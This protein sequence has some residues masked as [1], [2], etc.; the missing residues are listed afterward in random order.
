[1]HR[2]RIAKSPNIKKQVKID[3]FFKI[4]FPTSF[5]LLNVRTIKIE[6]EITPQV[7]ISQRISTKIFLS[8]FEVEF[9]ESTQSCPS[10]YRNVR[11]RNHR[12]TVNSSEIESS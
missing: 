1:M 8:N 6:K 3:I 9:E 11:I 7:Q 5:I 10:S 2:V 12:S 4:K